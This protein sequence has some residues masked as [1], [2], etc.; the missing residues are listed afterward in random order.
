[1]MNLKDLFGRSDGQIGER[2]GKKEIA[3]ATAELTKYKQG[4]E[5]L[6]NRVVEDELWWELR[7]WE[8]VRKKNRERVGESPDPASAYLFNAI[9]NKHADAMDNFPEAVVLP[10][11]SSDEAT[12]KKLSQI[13]PVVMEYNGFEDTY[14]AAW[15]EKLKHGTAIY[16]IFWNSKKDNGIGDIDIKAID[17][18]KIFWQP[19][20]SDIQASRNLFIVDVVDTDLLEA[21]Y[22][23][24]AGKMRGSAIDVK[25][26]ISDETVDTS[27]KSVVVDWYYKKTVGT[28]TVLHYVK[29]VDDIVLY[30]T[31]ND[32]EKADTGLYAHGEYPVV[33]DTLFPEKNTP[34]GFGYVAICK[35]PQIY[36]DRLSSNI[37]ETS[38]MGTKRRWL[39]SKSTNI[40]REQLL[41]WND[42]LIEVE[43]SLDD[44]RIREIKPSAV[45]GIYVSVMQQKVEEM[46]DTASNRD[47]NSGGAGS[48]VTAAA[49]IAALQEAGNKTSRVMIAAS[50]RAYTNVVRLA[51]EL[52]RQFYDETRTF[53]ITGTSGDYS[54]A[55]ISNAA[56]G[57]IPTMQIDGELQY[58]RPIFDLKIKA[59]KKS[60]FSTMAAN[61]LAKELYSLGFFNPDRAEEALGALDMMT[62]EGI[63][64]VRE[65]ISEGQT[66]VNMLR[67][68][69]ARLGALMGISSSSQGS[70]GASASPPPDVSADNG[71]GADI[72]TAATPMT[73]YGDRLAQRS[74]PSM[75]AVSSAAEPT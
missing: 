7:H 43:G 49:A 47:V 4:K 60:P 27:N 64:K 70:D 57:D 39:V 11:E 52:M 6:E 61:E 72:L 75:D 42:P 68:A 54:F 21:A 3:E 37:L 16:G 5:A 41:D 15:W 55:E 8:A 53:R 65:K 40:N 56:L 31:E 9:L 17:L 24:H 22:P 25:E 67:E 1:M 10:R 46:K 58:R 19:G 71:V 44:A 14:S 23:E 36:I 30:A 12:A 34:V 38:M 66:L 50:Y 13:M 74:A 18:L 73:S 33:F 35:E 29:Y 48:G 45:D 63:E 59:Q 28:K 51:I 26:Y 2:I 32:P 62:F 20:I 69:N